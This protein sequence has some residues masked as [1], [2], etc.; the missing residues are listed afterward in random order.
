MVID[1][2]VYNLTDMD[3]TLVLEK[4]TKLVARKITEETK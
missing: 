1:S 3:R 2:R 4:R